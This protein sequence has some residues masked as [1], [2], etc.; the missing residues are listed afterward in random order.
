MLRKME[1]ALKGSAKAQTASATAESQKKPGAG[2]KTSSRK[3]ARRAR[4]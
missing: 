1:E 3:N 2:A 4:R